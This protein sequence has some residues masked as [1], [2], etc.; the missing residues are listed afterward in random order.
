MPLVPATPV[1]LPLASVFLMMP[2]LNPTSPPPVPFCPTLTFPP[3]DEP[4]IVPKLCPTKPPADTFGQELLAAQSGPF[5]KTL[6]VEVTFPVAWEAV[7][8]EPGELSAASPPT[9]A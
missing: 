5:W 3:A 8:V 6:A 9:L 4:A 2:E 1:T 7:M